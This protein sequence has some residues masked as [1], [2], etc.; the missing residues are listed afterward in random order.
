MGFFKAKINVSV[1][2]VYR[3]ALILACKELLFHCVQLCLNEYSLQ[4]SMAI[5]FVL[6][7]S[8]SKSHS[9]LITSLWTFSPDAVKS[10]LEY[11]VYNT[12]CVIF[13][14]LL[15][16]LSFHKIRQSVRVCVQLYSNETIKDTINRFSYI[17]N[18]LC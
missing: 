11:S 2:L 1:C 17:L 6:T 10:G 8:H 14:Y 15:N 4:Y 18:S 5:S 3:E 9:A 16:Q 7:I 12:I 13:S